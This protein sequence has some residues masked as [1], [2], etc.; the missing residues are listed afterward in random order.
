MVGSTF[1]LSLI[2]LGAVQALPAGKQVE[3][4]QGGIIIGDGTGVFIPGGGDN[5]LPP[6]LVG[7]PIN[8]QPPCLLPPI[9]GGLEPPGNPADEDA[10]GAKVRVKRQITIGDGTGIFVPGQGELPICLTTTPISEQPPCIL[11]PIAGGVL[12]PSPPKEKRGQPEDRFTLPPDYATNTKKVIEKLQKDLVAL[13]N[14]RHKTAADLRE[15]KA[16]KAALL[17]L[18]GITHIS[19]PPGSGTTFTPGKRD[20][21]FSLDA[22]GTYASVCPGIEGAQIALQTL[23]HK[24]KHTPQERIIMQ[25]LAAF[26]KGC[27]IVIVKSP[28]GTYTIIKPSDK[29]RD[30]SL[31]EL[32]VAGLEA[33]YDELLQAAVEAG[34]PSFANWLVLQHIAD[35]LDNYS[36]TPVDRSAEGIAQVLAALGQP[37]TKRQSETITVG[38]R[39]CQ[40]ADVM[41]LRAALAALLIAYGD[42]VN[43]PPSIFL[44]QQVIVS[45]LQLCG[46][47][48][49]G[50]TTLVPGSPIPG[51]PMI[52]EVTVPGGPMKP[53]P[54]IPG[55][56]MKPS[57]RDLVEERDGP[58][59]SDATAMLK[60]LKVLEE[61]Y[62]TYGSGDIPHSVWLI[63]LNLVTVLQGIPGVKVPGWPILGPGTVVLTPSD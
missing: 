11:P 12:P 62:G 44:V 35:L 50:W 61:K 42:P 34:Q 8:E 37:K 4:R 40:V 28:D 15:I 25:K 5:P 16:L 2:G 23:M 54:T 49:A 27:G 38:T 45:A 53:D 7:T 52:P 57:T 24:D 14:K 17:Y 32:D 58:V 22:V 30:V 19:A 31:E 56:P 51:G 20:I 63:M 10:G 48:V 59:L 9:T 46:Q 55:G 33:A 60:A 41:G 21:G 6:C 1:A 39:T 36:A 13:Q 29:K 47:T 3:E 18:A 26:L 43:S